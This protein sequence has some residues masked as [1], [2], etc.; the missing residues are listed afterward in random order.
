[1]LSTSLA[2]F[3]AFAYMGSSHSSAGDGSSIAWAGDWVP[4]QDGSAQVNSTESTAQVYEI[5]ELISL[6]Q[7]ARIFCIDVREDQLKIAFLEATRIMNSGIFPDFVKPHVGVDQH[8]EFS[9]SL[10]STDGYLDIGVCGDGEISFHVRNDVN[11]SLTAY[12]DTK[13]D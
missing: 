3:D 9:I 8:G 1:M 4:R 7:A 6:Y 5:S 11:P 12:G 13:W 10:K 2:Q